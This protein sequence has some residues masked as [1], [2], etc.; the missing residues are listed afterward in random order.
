MPIS[1]ESGDDGSVGG[2]LPGVN[3]DQ[4]SDNC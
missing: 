4:F 1:T 2:S 3:L